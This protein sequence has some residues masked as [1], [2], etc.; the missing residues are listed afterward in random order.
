MWL[1]A[2]GTTQKFLG[3]ILLEEG[4]LLELEAGRHED[5]GKVQAVSPDL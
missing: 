3:G 4:H 2:F 1:W 5:S